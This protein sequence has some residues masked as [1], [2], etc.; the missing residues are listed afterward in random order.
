MRL[1]RLVLASTK[2]RIVLLVLAGIVGWH[3]WLYLAA[4]FKI[5]ADMP[6]DRNR[7]DVEVR[8]A[9]VPER[10]HVQELQRFGRVSG[11]RD[12]LVE[13]RGVNRGNLHALARPF[14]VQRVEP[15]QQGG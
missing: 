4:P 15:L 14:W 3:V 6:M 9:F 11:T 8:L 13:V 1:A 2:G 12:N 7:V 5:A 10:F